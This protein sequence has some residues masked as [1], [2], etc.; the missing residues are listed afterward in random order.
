MSNETLQDAPLVS[1]VTAC[2]NAEPF[3][4]ETIE[5][6]LAQTYRAVEQIL[7][8]DASTDGSW[9][10]IERYTAAHP[11]RVRALRLETNRGGCFARN[12]GA[13][14]ARGELLMFLDADDLISPDSVAA[15]VEVVRDVPRAL[16]TV[17]LQNK[18]NSLPNQLSGGEQQR[19]AIAR[20]IVNRP[21]LL[22]AD[23]P[24][25]NLDPQTGAD[26][27]AVL[28]KV[29]SEGTTIVMAT[30]DRAV[31]DS[32]RRRVVRLAEGRVVSDEAQGI[33]HPEDGV[34]HQPHGTIFVAPEPAPSVPEAPASQPDLSLRTGLRF[35]PSSAED[36][37]E[38]EIEEATSSSEA[39]PAPAP[40][41]AAA[42]VAPRPVA[43]VVAPAPIAPIAPIAPVA[44]VAS[45]PDVLE[46]EIVFDTTLPSTLRP[47]RPPLSHRGT[48]TADGGSDPDFQ[49]GRVSGAPLGSPENPLV[50][51]DRTQAQTRRADRPTE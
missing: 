35:S 2:H 41:V 17:G 47:V 40:T 28:Q 27:I 18:A 30:H 8:D 23:E 38:T 25:G 44:P 46:P 39:P 20:A 13:E 11:D 4:A 15:L 37:L 32:L 36:G 1:V 12:R 14:Q 49:R 50:L 7:V 33:Y 26:I 42:P 51:Y 22:L 5:S 21:A 34:L 6:V 3:V 31:V 19:V 9:S 24:T 29:N 16:E 48:G 10:V 45:T 43:P